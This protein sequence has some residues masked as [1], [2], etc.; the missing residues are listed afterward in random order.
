MQKTVCRDWT[1]RQLMST[2]H[3]QTASELAHHWRHL[4]SFG[5]PAYSPA[6]FDAGRFQY[7]HHVA[8]AP[9]PESIA[10][11]VLYHRLRELERRPV[12]D[13]SSAG[14]TATSAVAKE[15]ACCSRCSG[16]DED[17][18]STYTELTDQLSNGSCA[19]CILPFKERSQNAN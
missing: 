8:A 10:G 18:Q 17:A 7:R 16:D 12:V 14:R 13:G 9:P 11:Y 1:A 15:A 3:H 2:A 6:V 4:A 5:R 19:A